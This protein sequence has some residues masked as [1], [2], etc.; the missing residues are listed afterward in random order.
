MVLGAVAKLSKAQNSA[1]AFISSAASRGIGANEVLRQLTAA[2]VGVQ[3][4]WGLK[5]YASYAGI[6]KAGYAVQN[7]RHD[8][9]ADHNA[10]PLSTARMQQKYGMNVRIATTG[11]I[12]AETGKPLYKSLWVTSDTPQRTQWYID[13]AQE[14]V[15]TEVE[16]KYATE[17]NMVEFA[18]IGAVQRDPI[19]E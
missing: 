16:N 15:D 1:L 8:Y 9:F 6:E 2:G 5:T 18:V 19:W 3:R 17:E 14:Y 10:L 4:Q 13:K 7:V 11:E 12:D